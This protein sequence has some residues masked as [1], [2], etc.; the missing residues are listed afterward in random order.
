MTSNKESEIIIKFE[1]AS[2]FEEEFLEFVEEVL[3]YKEEKDEKKKTKK[4]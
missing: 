4:Q 3:N 1:P 2:T